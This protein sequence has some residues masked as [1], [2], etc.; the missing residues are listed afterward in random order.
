MNGLE[1][2]TPLYALTSGAL[3]SPNEPITIKPIKDEDAGYITITFEGTLDKNKSEYYFLKETKDNDVSKPFF[4]S[5]IDENGKYIYD[6]NWK[7]IIERLKAAKLNGADFLDSNY[8][9]KVYDSKNYITE[10]DPE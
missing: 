9:C 6:K 5:E 10:Y 1:L 4:E 7:T 3:V 8:L 2:A